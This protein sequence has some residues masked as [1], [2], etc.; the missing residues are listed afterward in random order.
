MCVRACAC[1]CSDTMAPKS[2]EK[3][4]ARDAEV[5][6]D[7]KV[8]REAAAAVE[9]AALDNFLETEGKRLNSE[10][11]ALGLP[12]LREVEEGEVPDSP[13]YVPT[14]PAYMPS[15]EALEFWGEEDE[16]KKKEEDTRP[17]HEQVRSMLLRLKGYVEEVYRS[18]ARADWE[19]AVT[20]LGMDLDVLKG[21]VGAKAV[22]ADLT[23][24]EWDL[25]AREFVCPSAK[26]FWAFVKRACA[27]A[28]TLRLPVVVVHDVVGLLVTLV[29]DHRVASKVFAIGSK[30]VKSAL[31]TT[32]SLW[33]A[34]TR[35]RPYPSASV[36]AA[37]VL[38][39]CG[40]V[41]GL[42]G[43]YD[44]RCVWGVAVQAS[45]VVELVRDKLAE[46]QEA[47]W[48]P[49]TAWREVVI[50]TVLQGLADALRETKEPHWEHVCAMFQLPHRLSERDDDDNGIVEQ[51]LSRCAK[52]MPNPAWFWTDLVGQCAFPCD[53]TLRAR[54]GELVPVLEQLGR[55][56]GL[57][58]L[59]YVHFLG[60]SL[61]I[62][63]AKDCVGILGVLGEVKVSGASPCALTGPKQAFVYSM[64][65][66]T[67]YHYSD[68]S[69]TGGG[70]LL[71]QFVQE[72][73]T[74]MKVCGQRGEEW[75]KAMARVAAL[76]APMEDR[77]VEYL[78]H[79]LPNFKTEAKL[80]AIAEVRTCYPDKPMLEA[81]LDA[82][83][84]TWYVGQHALVDTMAGAGRGIEAWPSDSY[85]SDYEYD[86][87][88]PVCSLD[89][90]S[91]E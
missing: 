10:L 61:R 7:A 68:L 43:R 38:R 27:K 45:D 72:A 80:Q 39:G 85:D 40:W 67:R 60:P 16:K 21:A 41:V 30:E 25:V 90:D 76:S 49:R 81:Q 56:A 34:V 87:G 28:N 55:F 42:A 22:C 17:F 65:A 47:V 23:R 75:S 20:T 36:A 84:D 58:Y 12:P 19:D 29:P 83:M 1:V 73:F 8:M 31:R 26:W 37:K 13:Q 82:I 78:V 54:R 57:V 50:I 71:S 48:R 11:V 32:L 24:A 77:V 70:P 64:A 6:T 89:A 52:D 46:L 79:A 2:M 9:K 18:R 3:K 51:P 4:R 33:R 69:C 15:A 14:S 62:M 74:F 66:K 53:D 63:T 86:A 88:S 91:S 5:V 59:V 35:P 44:G